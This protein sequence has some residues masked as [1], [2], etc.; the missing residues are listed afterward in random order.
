MCFDFLKEAL[1]SAPDLKVSDFRKPFVV[2]VSASQQ[3]VGAVLLQSNRD[4]LHP[5]A[6]FST[7]HCPVERNYPA[8]EKELLAIF[9]AY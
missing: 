2:D 5:M 4:K 3:A 8:Y 9:K 1:C 7:K 6:Y